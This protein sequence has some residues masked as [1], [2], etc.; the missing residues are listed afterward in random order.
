KNLT[1]DEKNESDKPAAGGNLE[2]EK[3]SLAD[4]KAALEARR[5]E[6]DEK[7]RLLEG[8]AGAGAAGSAEKSAA[9][10]PKVPVAQDSAR[11]RAA[12]GGL[13]AGAAA[14]GA[15]GSG[16]G[17]G[18]AART[19]AGASARSDGGRVAEAKTAQA[20]SEQKAP[21]AAFGPPL[22]TLRTDF[23]TYADELQITATE[24]KAT[25]MYKELKK[26]HP[27]AFDKRFVD[28]GDGTV[29]DR[30]AGLVW[31]KGFSDKNASDF[32][33]H[34]AQRANENQLG[35]GAN[36]RLP[37]TEELVFLYLDSEGDPARVLNF[38]E[39]NTG[40]WTA[41]KC[42]TGLAYVRRYK[43]FFSKGMHAR[44]PTGSAD[45]HQTKAVRSL[46]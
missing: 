1:S 10:G 31:E 45:M 12:A 15:A 13:A 19:D 14:S 16:P 24:R 7:R 9:G 36:W 46:K 18:A 26:E 35:G 11:A 8:G 28:N 5:R 38:P 3:K 37:T 2:A 44:P 4:R 32:A 6:L 25:E 21:A 34:Y 22:V 33:E 41:D 27:E 42:P 30:V 43:T 20:A 17:P 29:T 39:V 23:R 40:L